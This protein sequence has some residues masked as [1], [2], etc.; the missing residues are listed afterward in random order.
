M[1]ILIER[2]AGGGEYSYHSKL[3]R[4]VVGSDPGVESLLCPG[5]DPGLC[6]G[7]S[8]LELGGLDCV[9]DHIHN[10]IRHG[11]VHST[12]KIL[13]HIEDIKCFHLNIENTNISS[14]RHLLDKPHPC[15]CP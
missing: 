12:T 1:G 4:D 14:N 2:E 7:L 9:S 13:Q 5:Q 10:G 8:E 11:K 6:F 15:C 3:S